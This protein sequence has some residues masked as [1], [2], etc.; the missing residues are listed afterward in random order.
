[1]R[2]FVAIPLPEEWKSV[3]A[4]PQAAIGW[5]GRGVK[6]VEPRGMHLTLKFLGETDD[7]RRAEIDDALVAACRETAAFSMRISKTGV[8]PNPRRPRVYWAGIDA[9]PELI[10]LH[11]AIDAAMQKLNFPADEHP[12]RPH[13]TLARIKDP[14]GKD[15]MTD[16]V[17]NYALQSEPFTVR[18]V[19]LMR[20][21]LSAAGARYE[22]LRAYPLAG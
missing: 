4:Q 3:L 11:G 22:S 16:A 2:L 5:I 15:R 12:F 7:A 6:W 19:H 20:S 18:D 8:F 14:I 9:G 17:L 10:R 1:M 21:H 13:L